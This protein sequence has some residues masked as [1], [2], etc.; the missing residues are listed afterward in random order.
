M[1]VFVSGYAPLGVPRPKATCS[2]TS[3]RP[4][5]P[6]Y[7]LFSSHLAK[8]ITAALKSVLEVSEPGEL[9]TF[10]I[11][12]VQASAVKACK[13]PSCVSHPLQHRHLFGSF[14]FSG[15]RPALIIH[16]HSPSVQTSTAHLYGAL[17]AHPAIHQV[18]TLALVPLKRPHNAS[19]C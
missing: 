11:P 2:G 4:E 7:S 17:P 10:D 19:F 9:R 6:E 14:R 8:D 12:G 5:R 1:L 16:R 13:Q 18:L 15:G 3:D